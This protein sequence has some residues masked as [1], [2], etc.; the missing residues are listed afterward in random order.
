MAVVSIPQTWTD[1]S[2]LVAPAAVYVVQNVGVPGDL[3]ECAVGAAPPADSAEGFRLDQI[4]EAYRLAPPSGSTVFVRYVRND[5]NQPY[6]QQVGYL[7]VSD[8]SITPVGAFPT[9]VL[10]GNKAVTVQFFSE[11][12]SK[13]GT[14]WQFAFYNSALAGGASTDLIIQTG[15][16]F[17]LIKGVISYFKGQAIE[18]TLY[19][20][21]TFTGGV[22]LPYYNQRDD[23]QGAGLTTILGGATVTDPGLQVSPAIV[24]LGEGSGNP[25]PGV[26][27]SAIG[28]IERV[29]LPN[30]TYLYRVTNLD[31][32]ARPLTGITSW[33]EGP[34]SIDTAIT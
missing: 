27:V 30:S 18:S 6:P 12:N 19:K 28:A 31:G 10:D 29:L 22:S 26:N 8:A 16:Q 23:F 33:Y 9:S 15:A 11:L 3:I 32:S 24:A 5:G 2:T 4:K 21:P 34:L 7:S 14:Q 1:L 17:V 20:G 25:V 13:F